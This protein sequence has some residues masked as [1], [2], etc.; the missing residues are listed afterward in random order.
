MN[1]VAKDVC[2]AVREKT[3]AHYGVSVVDILSNRNSGNAWVARRCAFY[4]AHEI[5]QL[6]YNAIAREFGKDHSTVM[7]GCK[8]VRDHPAMLKAAYEISLAMVGEN[9]G[10]LPPGE[11]D[12]FPPARED[13]A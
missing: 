5:F 13:A 6:S 3:A 12:E 4:V 2:V 1:L 9:E 10:Y 8:A 7:T 11:F